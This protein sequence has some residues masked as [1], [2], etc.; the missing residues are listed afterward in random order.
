MVSCTSRT[1]EYPHIHSINNEIRTPL[2]VG[3]H[4]GYICQHLFT[5]KLFQRNAGRDIF[6][7]FTLL[8]CSEICAQKSHFSTIYGIILNLVTRFILTTTPCLHHHMLPHYC[9]Y[10][11]FHDQQ[12]YLIYLTCM[13]IVGSKRHDYCI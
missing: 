4:D 3:G 5:H 11:S 6:Q 1:L 9:R 7:N 12:Y 10:P 2:S 8:G 13:A